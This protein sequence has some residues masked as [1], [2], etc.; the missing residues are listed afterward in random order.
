MNEQ[1]QAELVRERQR[2]ARG[3]RELADLVWDKARAAEREAVAL[4]AIAAHYHERAKILETGE[5]PQEK[6]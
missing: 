1:E 2:L 6:T 3:W 4:K 5:T